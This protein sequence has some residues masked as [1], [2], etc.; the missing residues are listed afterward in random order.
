MKR[1]E[2]ASDI[3]VLIG[4][5]LVIIALALIWKPLGLLAFGFALIALGYV[6]AYKAAKSA[7]FKTAE[8]DTK[9]RP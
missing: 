4:V 7:P 1:L 2:L 5:V 9:G 3:L 6:C 8:P